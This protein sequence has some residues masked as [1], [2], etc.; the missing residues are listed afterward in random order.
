MIL[1]VWLLFEE[2]GHI[3]NR[4]LGKSLTYKQGWELITNYPGDSRRI[5]KGSIGIAYDLLEASKTDIG[6]WVCQW[7]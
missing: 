4:K 6:G 1:L 3:Q 2:G 7:G 5:W